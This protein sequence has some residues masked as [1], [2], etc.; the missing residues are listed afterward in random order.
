[1]ASSFAG[2][3]PR[4][5]VT[6]AGMGS[7]AM[8]RCYQKRSYCGKKRCGQ[9]TSGSSAGQRKMAQSVITGGDR[10][11]PL[12]VLLS[13]PTR[14]STR[15]A[16]RQSSRQSFDEIAWKLRIAK[17]QRDSVQ[18]SEECRSLRHLRGRHKDRD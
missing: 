18:A 5:A 8:R 6:S 9:K 2:P 4:E 13:I 11:Q 3:S 7:R 12:Y 1:M 15:L 10:T 16:I 14:C 17:F